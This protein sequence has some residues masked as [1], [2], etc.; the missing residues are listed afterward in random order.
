MRPCWSMG[1]QNQISR[2]SWLMAQK[3]IGM[4]SKLF[5]VL[6][7]LL[8]R[9]LINNT[10]VYSIGTPKRS[11]Q[12][13]FVKS[14]RHFMP[15]IQECKI[16]WG[17]W[18]FL[19]YNSLLVTIIRGSFGGKCPWTFKL[20]WFLAFSC[21]AMGRFHG[22]CEHFTY[23]FPFT[24]SFFHLFKIEIPF[25]LEFHLHSTSICASIFIVNSRFC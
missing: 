7:T 1:F 22:P 20:A 17:G 6:G 24:P 4:L 25:A 11:N 16:P 19:C 13:K 23:K 3:Q 9:W 8:L 5:M 10:L 12:T 18:R 15:P 14:T 21:Q 2:D